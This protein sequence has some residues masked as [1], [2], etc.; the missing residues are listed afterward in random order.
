MFM[1]TPIQGLQN[2]II[3]ICGIVLFIVVLLLFFVLLYRKSHNLYLQEK[4]LMQSLFEVELAK[5]QLEAQEATLASVSNELHD[6][7]G[8]LLNSTKMLIGVTQRTL[9]QVP[10]ALVVAETSLNKAIVEIRQLSKS[11]NKDWLQQ[12][13]LVENLQNEAVNLSASSTLQMVV[14]TDGEI[15]LKPN[16]QLMLFRIVQELLQNTVKHAQAT[17]FVVNILANNSFCQL[18]ITD[19]GKGLPKHFL[20]KGQGML[21]VEKRVHLLGGTVSWQSTIPQGTKVIMQIP[22]SNSIV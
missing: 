4:T 5:T 10:E 17:Q 3:I 14:Q 22:L 12:F 9:P 1:S 2:A 15:W 18:I 16:E 21:N 6:N 19:D 8:Q 11:L 7:I 13:S 20:Q